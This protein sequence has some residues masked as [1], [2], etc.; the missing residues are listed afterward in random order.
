MLMF[1][2]PG[3]AAATSLNGGNGEELED[4]PP[5][6]LA[7]DSNVAGN[8]VWVIVALLIVV[9]LIIL[10]IRFLAS[11]NR[12]WGGSCSLRTLAGTG[13]GP[14][15]SLQI[16]ELAGRIYV[17]GVGNEVTL[18]DKIDDP[19]E[20]EAIV[21]LLEQQSGSWG[22]VSD[23]IRKIRQGGSSGEQAEAQWNEATPF[24]EVLQ[25]KLQR[26]TERSQAMQ[27]ILRDSNQKDRLRDE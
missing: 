10:L 7:I 18:L 19:S 15:K 22:S 5:P 21:A 25:E 6:G 3:V 4:L 24:N 23:Y 27:A 11:R 9:G 17:V 12:G 2:W 1:V 14:N 26:Q 16:V 13:L 20:V 8:L